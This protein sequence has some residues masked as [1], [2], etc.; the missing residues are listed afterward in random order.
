MDLLRVN[1]EVIIRSLFDFL[2]C[3]SDCR[4]C[5]LCHHNDF[6]RDV[7]TAV[8]VYTNNDIWT[9]HGVFLSANLSDELVIFC[10]V[11]YTRLKSRASKPLGLGLAIR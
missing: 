6:L 4:L 7:S 1:L 8:V 2:F 11:N 10:S 5:I 9:L 3:I